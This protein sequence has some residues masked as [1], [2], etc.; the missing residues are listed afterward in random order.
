MKTIFFILFVSLS[1][2]LA[3][4]D[5][6]MKTGK[7]GEGIQYQDMLCRIMISADRIDS[8][9]NRSLTFNNEG[10]IQVFS[11]F[12]GTTNSNSTG[13]RVYYLFPF[14]TKK[15]ISD[16]D[17][18]HLT[19]VHPSGAKFVFDKNGKV[20]SPDLK[21]RVSQEINSHNNSGI[22]I[23]SY[24][25]GLVVDLGYKMGGTPA[26]NKNAVV[27]ITDKNNKKCKMINSDI[28]VVNKD[29]VKLKFKT[30]EALHFFLASKCPGLD[31]SDLMK[32]M[33]SDLDAVAKASNLGSAPKLD[34][35]VKQKDNRRRVEVK[36]PGNE[37][38]L[39][40]L[41]KTLSKKNS[42]K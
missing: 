11:N 14:K 29:D 12:P 32:P 19:V 30:N 5:C 34:E 13:A 41:V 40:A 7:Y 2:A 4:E 21:M 31:I 38:E 9:S 3:A 6:P 35:D 15:T 28:N 18:N 27:T 16:A 24:K 17:E 26:L 42:T 10:A 1:A 22:E 25:N 37:D 39:D 8:K 36:P 33:G 23:E 20:S